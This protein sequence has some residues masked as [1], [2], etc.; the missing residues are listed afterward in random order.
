MRKKIYL[1][2]KFGYSLQVLPKEYVVGFIRMLLEFSCGFKLPIN[3]Q[4]VVI[5]GRTVSL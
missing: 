5:V 1:L 3:R 2:G 4:H